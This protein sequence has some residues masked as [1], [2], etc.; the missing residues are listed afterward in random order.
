MTTSAEPLNH[1][2]SGKTVASRLVQIVRHI[3]AEIRVDQVFV[4][5]G[6]TALELADAMGWHDFQVTRAST[7]GIPELAYHSNHL[8][9]FIPK[10]GSYPWSDEWLVER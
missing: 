10:P 6:E 9:T 4:E 5:G 2:R 7:D 8:P 3:M 1:L